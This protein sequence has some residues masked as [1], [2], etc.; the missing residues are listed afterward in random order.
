MKTIFLFLVLVVG[1]TS[2]FVLAS[3]K[4]SRDEI[5]KLVQQGKLLSLDTIMKSYPEEEYGSLI[6]L[7]VE[8]DDG[9]IIYELKFLRSDGQVIEMKI[10]A[11]NGRLLKLE[12]ED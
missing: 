6:D 8:P 7:E 12:V 2:G 4:V 3:D 1:T 9:T 10:D 5:R 11:R